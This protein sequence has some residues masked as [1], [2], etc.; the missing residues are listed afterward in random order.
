MQPQHLFTHFSSVFLWLFVFSA[1]DFC[2]FHRSS[3]SH[4]FC[5]CLDAVLLIWNICR[6]RYFFHSENCLKSC[7]FLML[8]VQ[9]GICGSWKG[10]ADSHSTL[11]YRLCSPAADSHTSLII[12]TSA[13]QQK[14]I[15]ATFFLFFFSGSQSGFYLPYRNLASQSDL[16]LPAVTSVSFMDISCSHLSAETFDNSF[17]A[18]GGD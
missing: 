8:W 18:E 4:P 6:E 15:E 2:L 5:L 17:S 13:R 1:Y 16:Y 3:V 10:S 9:L 14:E 7:N 12:Q 11:S